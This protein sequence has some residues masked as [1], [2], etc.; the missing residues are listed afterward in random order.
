MK[1]RKQIASPLRRY[2]VADYF[3]EQ[4]PYGGEMA[5]REEII[6]DLQRTTSDR[7]LIDLYL[8]GLDRSKANGIAAAMKGR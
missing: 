5:T 3:G 7:Q 1:A 4:F 8:F 2:T 6:A